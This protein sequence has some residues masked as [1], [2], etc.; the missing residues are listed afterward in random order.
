MISTVNLLKSKT[1]VSESVE[2]LD[3]ALRNIRVIVLI[4]FV[5]VG[6]ATGGF[7]L[8]ANNRY[9]KSVSRNKQYIAAISN[10]TQKEVYVVTLKDRLGLVHKAREA[11]KSYSDLL[12][13][14][15]KGSDLTAIRSLSVDENSLAQVSLNFPS[16][17]QAFGFIE[18]MQKEIQNDRIQKLTLASLH[19]DEKSEVT[20]TISFEVQFKAP[21]SL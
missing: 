15:G 8:Y 13:F 9:N 10:Q 19:L 14:M 20:M 7:Y 11:Q 16:I 18:F 6:I 5:V 2:T 1:P 12:G 3:H 21:V 17:L 4:I